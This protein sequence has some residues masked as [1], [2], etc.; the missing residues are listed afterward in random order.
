MVALDTDVQMLAQPTF[1]PD[2]EGNGEGIA[3]FLLTITAAKGELTEKGYQL[4]LTDLPDAEGRGGMNAAG[5]RAFD[6]TE[7]SDEEKETLNLADPAAL[8]GA[9]LEALNAQ[10]EEDVEGRATLDIPVEGEPQ[11]AELPADATAADEAAQPKR[12]IVVLVP[13]ST[14]ARAT[15]TP[16]TP[17]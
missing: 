2:E 14:S 9:G 6:I 7:L 1:T 15:K 3:A 10:V 4:N 5:V 12:Q 16:P 17:T 11:L 8:E 13:Y